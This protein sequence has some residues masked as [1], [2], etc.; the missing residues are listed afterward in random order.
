MA[1]GRSDPELG[2]ASFKHTERE[3]YQPSQGTLE[4][5]GTRGRTA[6]SLFFSLYSASLSEFTDQHTKS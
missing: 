4:E 2:T 1:V 5:E 3:K 6:L